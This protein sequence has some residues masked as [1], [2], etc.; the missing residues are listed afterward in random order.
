M[1]RSLRAPTLR[2]EENPH[3]CQLTVGGRGPAAGVGVRRTGRGGHDL[4]Q[5]GVPA[6]PGAHHGTAVGLRTTAAPGPA[7]LTSI[8]RTVTSVPVRAR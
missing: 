5:R 8:G 1:G 2:P 4:S 7:P 6:P 3:I